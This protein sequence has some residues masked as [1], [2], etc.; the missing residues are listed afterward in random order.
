MSYILDALKKAEQKRQ[1]GAFPNLLSVHEQTD[2]KAAKPAR[3]PYILICILLVSIGAVLPRLYE[4]YSGAQNSERLPVTKERQGAPSVP[5]AR[6][7]NDINDAIQ[8]TTRTHGPAGQQPGWKSEKKSV[9][10]VPSEQKAD[11]APVDAPAP[12][13]AT[14]LPEAA[15][16]SKRITLKE[17]ELPP[18]IQQELPKVEISAHIYDS[19]PS[20]RIITIHGSAF[21][22]GDNVAAGLRLE[23]IIPEGVILSYKGYRFYKP[24]F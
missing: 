17:S 21:H 19:N 11:T 10:L 4:R 18:A 6:A 24:L 9:S 5:N 23:N 13:A 22:E 1:Q 8:E 14:S 20:A 12:A 15:A 2:F 3:W 7:A 16:S